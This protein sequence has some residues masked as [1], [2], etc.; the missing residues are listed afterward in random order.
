[1][2]SES[3]KPTRKGVLRAARKVAEIL[4]P[5]PLLPAEIGDA[6][7]WCK[8]ECL[9]PIGAFKIRGAWH[10]LY[11]DAGGCAGGETGPGARTGR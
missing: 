3:R 11:R 8:A 7:V 10:R 2:S 9:Q 1:M 4:P 5:T 6:N